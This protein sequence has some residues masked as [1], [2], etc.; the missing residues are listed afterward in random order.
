MAYQRLYDRWSTEWTFIADADTDVSDIES[1]Q[2]DAPVG[3]IIIA[4]N[5]GSAKYYM[6]FPTGSYQEIASGGGGGGGGGASGMVVEFEYDDTDGNYRFVSTTAAADVIAAYVAGTPVVFYI[7]GS[8]TYGVKEGY[9]SPVSYAPAQEYY[10]YEDPAQ[11][12][13][14][15][16]VNFGNIANSFTV[17]ASGYLEA[18]IFVD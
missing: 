3:S 13:C 4:G 1:N 14:S 2:P 12:A 10:G 9:I 8:T 16:S 7:P 11:F 18:T 5:S 6:K 17:D 15:S